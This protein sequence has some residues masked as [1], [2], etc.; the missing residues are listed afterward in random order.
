[1]S[2]KVF[3]LEC[4]Q[5]HVFEGWFR[6]HDDYA[7]Q[8]EK[9]LVQCPVCQSIHVTRRLSAPSVHVA[10][11][12]ASVP[13]QRPAEGATQENL[14]RELFVKLREQLKQVENVGDGFVQE[15][16]R[17]HAGDAEERPIR[18]T[19]T[20]AERR[21]LADEGIEAMAVPFPLDDDA[22]H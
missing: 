17:I 22:V 18:G 1:M 12:T 21:E 4:D 11:R 15:A 8:Q 14:A 3:D 7:S 9:G 19:A 2:F 13:V 16:R 5:G 10:R 20:P 6:S